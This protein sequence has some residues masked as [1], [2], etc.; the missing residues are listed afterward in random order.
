MLQTVCSKRENK[1][2]KRVTYFE[3][4]RSN[5]GSCNG[6]VEYSEQFSKYEDALAE[7]ERV[8]ASEEQ[9]CSD[10]Q[11]AWHSESLFKVTVNGYGDVIKRESVC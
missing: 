6:C 3:L 11:G 4:V 9:Y 2:S 7:L 5:G 1:M 8:Q 10:H